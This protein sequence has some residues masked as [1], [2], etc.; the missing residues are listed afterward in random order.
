MFCIFLYDSVLAFSVFCDL[1]SFEESVQTYGKISLNLWLFDF[2]LTAKWVVTWSRWS[3]SS[4][5]TVRL[6]FSPGTEA[7][8]TAHILKRQE[9]CSTSWTGNNHTSMIWISYI[10]K[11]LMLPPLLISLLNHFIYI[12]TDEYIF[13][14]YVMLFLKF[15]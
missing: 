1:D 11:I 4:F 12:I 6:L 7:S 15:F 13:I 8:T 3:L 5:S 10:R 2:F 9:L 14:F